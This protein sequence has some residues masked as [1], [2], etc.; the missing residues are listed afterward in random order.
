MRSY[1]N[2][3]AGWAEDTA[4]AI[5]EGRWD[6]IDRA[7]LAD[8]VTDL[9]RTAKRQLTSSFRVLLTHL[10]KLEYQGEKATRSWSDTI[11]RE[12]RNAAKF[13]AESPSLRAQL[14]A[15][16]ADAYADAVYQAE[17]ETGL[18]LHNF[19]DRCQW[20]VSEIMGE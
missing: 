9:G 11:K 18:A 13:L 17:S 10:L 1:Q 15:I 12:R 20:S 6:E 8:E 2:D 3:Y 16:I 14:D 7:S 5:A 4:Q 19:P